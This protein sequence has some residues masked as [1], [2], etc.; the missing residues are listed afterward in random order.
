[1]TFSNSVSCT[2]RLHFCA[3]HR[4]MNHEG[5][6][7]SPHGH[8]YVIF[9]TAEAAEL[10]SLGR[11]IDFSVLK[12]RVGTWIDENWDHTFLVYEKDKEMIVAMS[13]AP[14]AKDPFICPFNPTAENIAKYL[15]N[16][17]GPNVLGD[18]GVT[19]TKVLV[20]ETENCFAEASYRHKSTRPRNRKLLRGSLSNLG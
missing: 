11:I 16:V 8:N 20:H 6:C 9:I 18:T 4:V 2:R 15:L 1:M 10:D 3:G 19:V 13:H 7:A 17:V 14:K 12:E 5:K